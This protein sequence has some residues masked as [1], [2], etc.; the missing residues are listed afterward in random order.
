MHAV[1]Q[2]LILVD[3]SRRAELIRRLLEGLLPDLKAGQDAAGCH[4]VVGDG[5]EVI[6]IALFDDRAGAEAGA[7]LAGVW[8][9]RNIAP[10]VTG[11]PDVVLGEVVRA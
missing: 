2:R 1:I 7:A 5:A 4:L 11:G 3:P 10:L 6:C 9:Q 8:T